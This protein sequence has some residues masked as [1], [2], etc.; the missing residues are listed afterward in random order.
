MN[1]AQ[2]IVLWYAGLLTVVILLLQALWR[3]S[4]SHLIAAIAVIAALLIY[5]LRPHPAARKRWL[6]LLV[7]VPWLAGAATLL[8]VLAY[9]LWEE[10][11][12]ERAV[13][14]VVRRNSSSD[15]LLV[16]SRFHQLPRRAQQDALGRVHSEFAQLPVT[17]QDSLL[18]DLSRRG[19]RARTPVATD[20]VTSNTQP[21][22]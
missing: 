9:P 11:R 2:L 12:L 15:S 6:V 19:R 18:D 7:G 13:D 21:T 22:P 17:D 1:T 3:D 8:G 4:A 20:P 5:T 14:A 10:F 16:D